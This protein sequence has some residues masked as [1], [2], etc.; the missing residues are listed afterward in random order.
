MITIPKEIDAK[1][2]AKAYRA[3]G[4]THSYFIIRIPNTRNNVFMVRFEMDI[5]DLEMASVG[6]KYV[7]DGKTIGN[8][9]IITADE[10]FVDYCFLIDT[11]YEDLQIIVYARTKDE[12]MDLKERIRHFS[13]QLHEA[14]I[15]GFI[16]M[17]E[18][19]AN[20]FNAKFSLVKTKK[21][22]EAHIPYCSIIEGECPYE[23]IF[24]NECELKQI[25]TKV[26]ER[27]KQIYGESK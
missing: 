5:R 25:Y 24:C 6:Y 22:R 11:E 3:E 21:A 26:E 14:Y 12:Q 13:I 9:R 1:I 2:E 4:M 8:Y 19:E 7:S 20:S 15:G 18:K 27:S 10:A 17:E 23:N 16:G